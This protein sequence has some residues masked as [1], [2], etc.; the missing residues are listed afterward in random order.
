MS[1]NMAA[2]K[3]CWCVQPRPAGTRREPGCAHL[4][5]RVGL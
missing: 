3:L 1:L 2:N 5:R 4:H